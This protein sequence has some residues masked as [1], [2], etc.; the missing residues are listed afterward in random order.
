LRRTVQL[1][2]RHRSLKRAQWIRDRAGSYNMALHFNR[3][4]ILTILFHEETTRRLTKR[5]TTDLRTSPLPMPS[6]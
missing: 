5:P 3:W 6:Y 4:E 2:V 1:A